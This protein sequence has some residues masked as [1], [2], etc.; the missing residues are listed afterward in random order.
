MKVL[1]RFMTHNRIGKFNYQWGPRVSEGIRLSRAK[2]IKEGREYQ[3]GPR[4]MQSRG[5]WVK[6]PFDPAVSEP[7]FWP[8]LR[9][10]GLLFCCDLIVF[11]LIKDITPHE[12]WIYFI[13]S[14]QSA[15]S[16]EGYPFKVQTG[17]RTNAILCPQT[18]YTTPKGLQIP[19]LVT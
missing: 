16:S 5:P 19:P 3:G 8:S 13:H 12:S 4:S 10:C 14:L 2:I 15:P 7:G 1:H 6:R 17:K 18:I 11:A 9:L